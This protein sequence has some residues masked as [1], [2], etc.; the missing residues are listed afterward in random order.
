[1]GLFDNL[2]DQALKGM[3]GL[4]SNLQEK[5]DEYQNP[6][7]NQQVPP[8]APQQTQQEPT[9][10]QVYNQY[11]E[12]LIE[13]ALADGELTEKEKQVLFKKAEA[14]GID[15]DEFEMVLDAKLYEKQKSMN[16]TQSA[17]QS[18]PKSE[19][20]GDVRKC[21]RCG[22]IVESFTTHCP[23]CGHEFSN[24]GTVSSFNLLSLK[25]ETLENQK[26]GSL[27]GLLKNQSIDRQK[28]SLINGFPVP[29]TKEDILEF[30]SMAAPLA[31]KI[32]N[33]FSNNYSASAA[34]NQNHNALAPAWKAKLEQVI[35]KARLSMRGDKETLE[36]IEKYAKELNIK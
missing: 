6:Q 14:Q 5:L 32:G 3:N 34:S 26:K 23:D 2:K 18:A 36:E 1:M 28:A 31:K 22:A 25:L 19:K 35:I 29:T 16:S 4:A 20:Y 9:N 15:L 17:H 13:M 27:L 10:K 30:L 12:N 8:P 11:L 7:M 33:F 21:P 24:I